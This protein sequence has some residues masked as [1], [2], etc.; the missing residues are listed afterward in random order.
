MRRAKH[1]S[2]VGQ[3][4]G[5][6]IDGL[7]IR[8]R[9]AEVAERA[10]PGHGEGDLITGSQNTHM[11]ILVERQSR[12]TLVGADA[13]KRLGQHSNGTEHADATTASDTVPVIIL[14]SRNGASPAQMI[15]GRHLLEGLFV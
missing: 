6:I 4:R 11:A 8:D 12:F 14:G 9:Q 2:A 15:Y 10:I 3:T 5:Q 13:G 7:S 1:A